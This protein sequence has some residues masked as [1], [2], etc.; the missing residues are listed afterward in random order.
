ML[1]RTRIAALSLAALFVASAP[2]S[3]QVVPRTYQKGPVTLVQ[4]YTIAPGKLNIFMQDFATN[5]RAGL[6]YGKKNG[7]ILAY[8]V[9]TTIARR[10]GEPNLVTTITFKDLASYDRSYE[11]ADRAAIAAYGSL[12]RAAAAA[13]KRAEYATLVGAV[14]YQNLTPLN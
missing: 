14:L 3:A 5:Q 8:G 10:A 1:M 4:Q 2:A 9:A 12:D 6:E 11:A 13:A 7:G